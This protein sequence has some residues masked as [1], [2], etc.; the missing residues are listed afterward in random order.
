ME[1]HK[2]D[3]VGP[4][5]HLQATT[6]EFWLHPSEAEKFKTD[7]EKTAIHNIELFIIFFV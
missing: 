7:K 4:N 3:V 1:L 5:N 6:K 2:P